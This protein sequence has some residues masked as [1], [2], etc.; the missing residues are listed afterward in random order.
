MDPLPRLLAPARPL[1]L[2]QLGPILAAFGA[3]QDGSAGGVIGDRGVEV[4]GHSWTLRE[5]I[6]EKSRDG[7]KLPLDATEVSEME[8]FG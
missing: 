5:G 1:R 2:A 4:V 6:S 7:G 3:G 8:A